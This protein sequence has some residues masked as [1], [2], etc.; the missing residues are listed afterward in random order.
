MFGY[1]TMIQWL[2]KQKLFNGHNK[3]DGSMSSTIKTMV[4]LLQQQKW[5]NG[6][7]KNFGS[8][9]TTTTKVQW[10]QQH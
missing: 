7:S 5:F 8:I 1:A 2:Q 10:L 6:H 3:N 4:P 9:A